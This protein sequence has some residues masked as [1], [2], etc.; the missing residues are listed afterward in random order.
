[1]ELLFACDSEAAIF[2]KRAGWVKTVA[3]A[4]T[5]FNTENGADPRAARRT[6]LNSEYNSQE[7]VMGSDV[8]EAPEHVASARNNSKARRGNCIEWA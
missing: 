7:R 4:R 2:P 6:S 3:D 8:G 1:M 5:N